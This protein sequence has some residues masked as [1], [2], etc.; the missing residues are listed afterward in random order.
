M[1]PQFKARRLQG[2]HEARQAVNSAYRD[3]WF[4]AVSDRSQ[5]HLPC[6]VRD[7]RPVTL[8]GDRYPVTLS[9]P[10][11][12]NPDTDR[13]NSPRFRKP[14]AT[15]LQI[16]NLPL[17]KAGK[18]IKPTIALASYLAS[19]HISAKQ[20]LACVSGHT[21]DSLSETGN[22]ALQVIGNDHTSS[23]R[24][25]SDRIDRQ[26]KDR[27]ELDSLGTSGEIPNGV[28]N[29]SPKS[30]QTVNGPQLTSGQPGSV[31]TQ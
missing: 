20:A 30:L 16:E 31:L 1:G 12:F 15:H 4:L 11:A 19:K 6:K 24:G 14:H 23:D 22:E 21:G 10:K 3:R 18:R 28:G 9:R 8:T 17:G 5:T 2:K 7:T 25:L 27:Q 26:P 29:T 13:P